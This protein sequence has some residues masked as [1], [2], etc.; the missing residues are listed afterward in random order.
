MAAGAFIF[1]Q[2]WNVGLVPMHVPILAYKSAFCLL[3]MVY[4]IAKTAEVAIS[5]FLV[6]VPEVEEKEETPNEPPPSQD[7]PQ[8][9]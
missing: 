9:A 4:L 7:P 2:A 8:P 6:E 1:Q 3:V 5:G